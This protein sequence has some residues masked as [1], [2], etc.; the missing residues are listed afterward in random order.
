[1][2][3][4]TP[5]LAAET[6]DRRYQLLARLEARART[7]TG[8]VACGLCGNELNPVGDGAACRCPDPKVQTP[9]EAVADLRGLV[10]F[11]T[12]EVT[13]TRRRLAEAVALAEE[14]AVMLRLARSHATDME[15]LLTFERGQVARFVRVTGAILGRAGH[16][17][18]GETAVL[19]A[20]E[21]SRPA[22]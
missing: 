17:P 1:M 19:L 10:D 13:T 6:A 2:N 8:P 5:D 3:A 16:V 18:A 14:T 21:L 20:S 15:G 7:Y 11:L 22:G 9:A 12:E 4:T